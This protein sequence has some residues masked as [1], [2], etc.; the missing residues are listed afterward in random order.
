MLHI[1]E[2]ALKI[3]NPK[4]YHSQYNDNIVQVVEILKEYKFSCRLNFLRNFRTL[5]VTMMSED[6]IENISSSVPAYYSINQNEIYLKS[7]FYDYFFNHELFH[8]ASNNGKISPNGIAFNKLNLLGENLNEG[9]TEYLN[10]KSL[11]VGKSWSNYQLELFVIQ[12][13]VFIYGEKILEPYFENNSSKFFQQFGIYSNEVLQIDKRLKLIKNNFNLQMDRLRYLFFSDI[14]PDIIRSDIEY[15]KQIRLNK[16]MITGINL[17]I[18]NYENELYERLAKEKIDIKKVDIFNYQYR[19]LKIGKVH[20][21]FILEYENLQ[22]NIF[23]KIISILMEM[24]YDIEIS[25]D[26]IRNFVQES[27]FYK[28]DDFKGLYT[29]VINKKLKLHVKKR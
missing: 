14:G 24:A 29:S 4:L 26:D 27:L 10:L 1:Y 8:V 25:I 11:K 6:K 3:S 21:E 9:I 22:K 13:L 19:N 18:C 5:K 20:N 23:D 15:L 17:L 7:N 2:A 16:K 12:F 28:N